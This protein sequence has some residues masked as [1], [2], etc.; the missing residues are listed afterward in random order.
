MSRRGAYKSA[1]GEQLFPYLA[2][3][4]CTVGAL[5]V[6][7]LAAARQGQA[8]AQVP[9]T[10]VLSSEDAD[11]IKTEIE[12]LQWRTS[13]LQQSRAKTEAQLGERRL[14][15]GH[16]EDHL[17]RLREQT[18]RMQIEAEELERIASPQAQARAAATAAELGRLQQMVVMARQ[19]AE[20][21]KQSGTGSPSYAVVP[22]QGPNE[23]RRRPIYIECR[24][25]VIL[26]QPEGIKLSETDFD[27][28]MVPDAW[29]LYQTTTAT[30]AHEV[31]TGSSKSNF[32]TC[33]PSA[34]RCLTQTN[35]TFGRK[36]F[37]RVCGISSSLG[38]IVPLL[39]GEEVEHCRVL[40]RRC[41]VAKVERCH[42]DARSVDIRWQQSWV[43]DKRIAESALASL[44]LTNNRDPTGNLSQLL[45]RFSQKRDGQRVDV[46][47]EFIP[48]E[49]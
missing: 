21:A 23:T 5:V 9:S 7:L 39:G 6:L 2:V 12:G 11:A 25:D 10:P 35:Q 17:R 41:A 38:E 49:Q 31:M 30:I 18:Q 24:G 34:A 20:E 27:G 15:L 37:C 45:L 29:R 13:Q 36:A 43:F 1:A 22:Y 4:T 28:P 48:Q 33:D 44:D 46:L 3:L 14:Q 8:Q 42:N 40:G 32:L 47:C 26:L 19:K 16:I